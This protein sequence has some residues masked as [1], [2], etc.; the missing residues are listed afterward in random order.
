MGLPTELLFSRKKIY[1]EDR[2][3]R[4]AHRTL[5]SVLTCVLCFPLLAKAAEPLPRAK[6][7]E[8]GMSSERLALIGK[9]IDSEVARD[10]LPGGVLAVARRGKLVHFAAYGYLDKATGTP[11]RTD[12]I[13]NIASMTK[14][15]VAV[16]ALQL[17]EQGRLLIDDPVAKYFP[18]FANMQVAV[19]NEKKDAIVDRVPA[20]RK[21]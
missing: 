18:Q 10:Q 11:M 2:T 4:G 19:L 3:M 1:R 14:P 17:H 13:F 8:V 15:T 6:P 12:A 21:I 5:A 16:A 7:E 9:I 20:A